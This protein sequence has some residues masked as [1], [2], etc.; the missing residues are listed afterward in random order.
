MREKGIENQSWQ[1][2][3]AVESIVTPTRVSCTA[4]KAEMLPLTSDIL[5]TGR[6]T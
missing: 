2:R 3:N 5:L 4:E 1:L 6:Y